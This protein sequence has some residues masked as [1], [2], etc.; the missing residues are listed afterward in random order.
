MSQPG[1]ASGADGQPLRFVDAYAELQRIAAQLKPAPDKIPDVDAIEPLV[2][3]A[4]ELAD[5][6]QARIDAVRALIEEQQG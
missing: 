3:R 4:K 1:Q 2:R 5:Y 6:C